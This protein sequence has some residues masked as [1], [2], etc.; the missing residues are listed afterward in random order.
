MTTSAQCGNAETRATSAGACEPYGNSGSSPMTTPDDSRCRPD[1]PS[2]TGPN[3]SEC[4]STNPTPG[5][6]TRFGS[7]SGQCPSI[8][9]I[10]TRPGISGN[11]TI[12]AWPET[13][14][15][16]PGATCGTPGSPTAA[17]WE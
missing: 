5:W 10:G 14:Q 8:S 16:T 4:T 13:A 3:S 2:T 12:A 17:G 15:T 7:S 6:S 1:R 9:S 11:D